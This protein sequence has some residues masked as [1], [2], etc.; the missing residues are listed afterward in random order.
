MKDRDEGE[1]IYFTTVL[2]GTGPFRIEDPESSDNCLLMLG[3]VKDRWPCRNVVRYRKV[4]GGNRLGAGIEGMWEAC[5][6]ILRHS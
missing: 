5:S 1:K 2:S 6:I 3:S 4:T